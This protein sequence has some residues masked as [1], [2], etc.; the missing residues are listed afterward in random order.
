ML[1]AGTER[2]GRSKAKCCRGALGLSPR[3]AGAAAAGNFPTK[4]RAW[5]AAGGQLG[6]RAGRVNTESSQGGVVCAELHLLSH[7]LC[8]RVMQKRRFSPFFTPPPSSFSFSF[9]SFSGSFPPPALAEGLLMPRMAPSLP[10]GRG[11]AERG[12]SAG[13]L[14]ASAAQPALPGS[15][16]CFISLQCLPERRWRSGE[17]VGT[18]LFQQSGWMS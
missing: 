9:L 3:P 16:S 12:S 15:P 7:I 5:D 13:E 10:S 11:R 1:A 2:E 6:K 18:A 14:R 17:G 8:C 4:E